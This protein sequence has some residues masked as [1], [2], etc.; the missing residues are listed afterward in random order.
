MNNNGFL[1]DEVKKRRN[2]RYIRKG[3]GNFFIDNNK[4]PG[5]VIFKTDK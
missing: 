2:I 3:K 5:D 1:Q 4:I